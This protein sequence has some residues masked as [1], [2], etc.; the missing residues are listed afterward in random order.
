MVGDGIGTDTLCIIVI[1][2]V[3]S[4]NLAQN[5]FK[6]LDISLSGNC[7]TAK[8]IRAQYTSNVE[9][10]NFIR[11]YGLSFTLSLTFWIGKVEWLNIE[12]GPNKGCT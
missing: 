5:R 1:I 2:Q 10:K 4:G 11:K 12:A 6:S 8:I 9:P 3:V 7:K